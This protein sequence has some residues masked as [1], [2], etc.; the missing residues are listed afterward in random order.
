MYKIG[1]LQYKVK[2]LA[3]AM[4]AFKQLGFEIERGGEKSKN[5]FIWFNEGPYIE[6][7]E[8]NRTLMPFAYIFRWIYGRAMKSAMEK[9]VL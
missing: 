4:E 3:Q 9:M 8:M 2:N 5:A 7:I 1:H 6:L